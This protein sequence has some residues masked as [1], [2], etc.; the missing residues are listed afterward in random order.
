MKERN[1]DFEVAQDFFTEM[2]YYTVQDCL[3]KNLYMLDFVILD[4]D[5]PPNSYCL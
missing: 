4:I 1:L 2:K 5:L 3:K